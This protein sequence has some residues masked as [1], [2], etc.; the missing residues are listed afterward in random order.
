MPRSSGSLRSPRILSLALALLPAAAALLA[1]DDGSVA[2]LEERSADQLLTLVRLERDRAD[3]AIYEVLAARGDRVGFEALVECSGLVHREETLDLVLDAVARFRA[4][5][6][7]ADA[8]RAWL[9]D[10]AFGEAWNLH[11]PAARALVAFG[12]EAERELRRIVAE[13]GNDECREI[14]I[15]ALVPALRVQGDAQALE[16]LL[17]W[18]RPPQSGSRQ[19]GVRTLAGFGGEELLARMADAIGDRDLPPTVRTM[20]VEALA[21][22]QGP[23]VDAVLIQALRVRETAV[24][25]AAVEALAARGV[26]DASEPIAR[27]LLARDPTLRRA[28]IVA[29]AFLRRGDPDWRARLVEASRS[30]DFALRLGAIEA[31]VAAGDAGARELLL[32]LVADEH[33][34]VRLRVARALGEIRDVAVIPPLIERLA[35]DTLRVREAV[36]ASLALLTGVDH[37]V[38]PERWRAWWAAEGE[39]FALPDRDAALAAAAERERRRLAGPTVVSFFGIP[40]GSD[41]VAFVLDT[42]GSMDDWTTSGRTRLEVV[43]DELAATLESFPTDGR[44]NLIFFSSRVRCWKR[45]LVERDADSLA[46]AVDYARSQR[47]NGSTALYD[48]LVAALEDEEVDTIVLLTDGQ[49][50]AG[51]IEDATEIL[52]DVAMRNELREVV[53]HCVSVSYRSQ[54]LEGLAE[55]TGGI[56]REVR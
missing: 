26:V 45:R 13:H 7:V 35:V 20:V 15:G 16:L 36:R 41:R 27:F 30:R 53:I 42:S 46:Q 19:L 51:A 38:Q 31:L 49:P 21:Q 55:A 1:Q 3:P 33:P 14:A 44:F 2:P 39:G 23:A 40:L 5:D 48:G 56:Y 6:G 54:L 4:V 47:P 25:L 12:S 43:T 9:V 52:A 17:C 32:E 28:A 37:G 8:A 22:S 11:R 24:R 29:L 10:R 18:Y 34:L 50:T